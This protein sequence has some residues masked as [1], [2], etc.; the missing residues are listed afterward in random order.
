MGKPGFFPSSPRRRRGGGRGARL[1]GV[2]REGGIQ[3]GVEWGQEVAGVLRVA[4]LL[5]GG[6][7]CTAPAAERSGEGERWEMTAGLICNI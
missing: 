1:G 3:R 7:R 4:H 5:G 6:R 2:A